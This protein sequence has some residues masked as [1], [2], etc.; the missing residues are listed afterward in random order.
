[1]EGK[2]KYT[3]Q[4]LKYNLGR[5]SQPINERLSYTYSFG[6]EED[7]LLAYEQYLKFLSYWATTD[8]NDLTELQKEMLI[9]IKENQYVTKNIF[10]TEEDF[11]S[12]NSDFAFAL[13]DFTENGKRTVLLV[14]TMYNIYPNYTTEI[15]NF[16]ENFLN[17]VSI[18]NIDSIKKDLIDSAFLDSEG[19]TK[20]LNEILLKIDD[21][22]VEIPDEQKE[23]LKEIVNLLILEN[24]GI[25]SPKTA[26]TKVSK[27]KPEIKDIT[28]EPEIET[29]IEPE[30]EAEIDFEALMEQELDFSSLMDDILNDN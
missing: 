9:Q 18:S 2:D 21:I 4:E 26:K 7:R 14:D 13:I 6:N 17:D 30:I 27:P 11:Y 29:E 1:M 20:K 5:F 15:I 23:I 19:R 10:A 3:Q 24:L 12:L 22:S 25:K 8:Y 28:P 16:P